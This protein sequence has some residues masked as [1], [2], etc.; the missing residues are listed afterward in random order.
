MCALLVIREFV[1]RP[2]ANAWQNLQIA[3]VTSR[4]TLLDTSFWF[5]PNLLLSIAILL[6]CRRYLYSLKLGFVLFLVNLVYVV[7]I[8]TSWFSTRHTQALLGFV[9]YLWLGSYAAHNFERV[10]SFLARIPTAALVAASAIAGVAA[11][12][13]SHLLFVLHSFDPLNT[14]R[15][16]N[17]VFSISVVLMIFKFRHA[18]WP[19]FIDVRRQTFGLYLSHGIVLL[20]LMRVLRHFPRWAPD[21]ISVSAIEGVVLWIAVSVT[22]YVSCLLVTMWLARRPSLQ[23][24]V[25]LVPE[26]SPAR[27]DSGVRDANGFL[28]SQQDVV[29]LHRAG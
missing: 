22:T 17:Q 29:L 14:L 1:F 9:F 24:M 20:L 4:A 25:G 2:G 13:E 10:S 21:S 11:Y 3:Y 28:V 6:I 26:D 27:R 15:L 18:T 7:N 12:G 19:G 16:S 5:V 8:Y 23:W